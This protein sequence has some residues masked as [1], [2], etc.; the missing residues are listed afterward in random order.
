MFCTGGIRCEKATS[1]LKTKGRENIYHLQGG[2]L[3]YLE[4][5]KNNSSW[6]GEC[7]VFDNRVTVDK[8]LKKGTYELCYACRMPLSKNDIKNKDY[9]KGVSCL[10]CYGKKT[11]AQINKYEMRNKQLEKVNSYD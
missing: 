9:I 10:N 2:I 4:E 3:K 1:Y 7:F 5:I 6:V 8:N 11:Q